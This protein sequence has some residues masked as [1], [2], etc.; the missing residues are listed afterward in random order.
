VVVEDAP[1]EM[2]T[3]TPVVL[4]FECE[5]PPVLYNCGGYEIPQVPHCR[6]DPIASDLPE[7]V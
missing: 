4:K 6:Y 5:E 7:S 3:T 2:E 1:A